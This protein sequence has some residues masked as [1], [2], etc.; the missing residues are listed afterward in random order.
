LSVTKGYAAPEV[1]QTY[2]GAHALC[3][4][5]GETPQLFPTLRGLYWFHQSLGA[6]QTARELGEQLYW[7][8]QR[9][10]APT[11]RLEAH[12]ALGSTLFYL[13][14]YATAWTHFEQGL[15]LADL[16]AKRALVLHHDPSPG[17]WYLGHTALTLW[18]LGSNSRC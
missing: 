1:E 7:L 16:T 12:A 4:R 8:A 13:G 17:V 5:V 15:T 18:C 2:A 14:E 10:V 9:E 11:P 6:L 3:Q